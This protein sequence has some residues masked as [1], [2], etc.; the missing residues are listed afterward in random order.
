[1]KD[2]IICG[3]L[4]LVLNER[5]RR[6]VNDIDFL[7]IPDWYG[8]GGSLA[9]YC[10]DI[11][12]NV[13]H[14]FEVDSLQITCWKVRLFNIKI[15]LLHNARGTEFEEVELI[16]DGNI[17]IVA[18]IEKPE[19]AIAFKEKYR[20]ADKSEQSREKHDKDLA[21]IKGKHVFGRYAVDEEDDIPF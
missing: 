11:D 12:G 9:P 6:P 8:R 15:D 1:M 13:S 18:K 16:I 4:G 5:L 19:I 14:R 20:R 3:S 10:D 2:L 21:A 7:T 17:H